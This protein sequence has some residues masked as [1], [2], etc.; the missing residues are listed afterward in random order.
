MAADPK[1][2]VRFDKPTQ[3]W[4]PKFALRNVGENDDRVEFD[5][6]GYDTAAEEMS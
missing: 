6:G 5:I 4:R 2:C 3:S 1:D